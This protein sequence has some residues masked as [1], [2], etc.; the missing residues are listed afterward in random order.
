M[1]AE[2]A[3]VLT[4]PLCGH[5]LHLDGHSLRCASGHSFDRARQGYVNLLAGNPPPGTAD[6]AEMV[7]AREAFLAAGHYQPLAEHIAALAAQA[8]SPGLVLDAGAG[9]GYYLDAVLRALPG[10]SGLALDISKFALRRA[11][12]RARTAAV[13]WDL[14]RPLPVKSGCAALIINVFAPRNGAEFR[15]VLRRDGALLVVTPMA[16]HLAEL[17]QAFGM[18]TVDARKEERLDEGLAGHFERERRETLVLPLALSRAE[19]LT[20]VRMGPS[21]HHLGVEQLEE[22]AGGLEEPVRVNAAFTLSLYR[23]RDM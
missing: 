7:Q 15:R 23:P 2:L 9:T 5:E 22:R 16:Q 17:V 12:R 21:A 11:A 19:A 4:C 14:W 13:V 18:L 6:T 3:Q 20:L 10:A 8:A 1:L